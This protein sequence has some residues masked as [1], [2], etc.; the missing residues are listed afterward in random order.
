MKPGLMGKSKDGSRHLWQTRTF[1]FRIKEKTMRSLS[2]RILALSLCLGA[3]ACH[4]G[5]GGRSRFLLWGS[6]DNLL[7]GNGILSSKELA[8]DPFHSIELGSAFKVNVH[9]APTCRAVL[10]GDSNLLDHVKAEVSN[11]VLFLELPSGTSIQQKQDLSLELWMPKLNNATLSGAV[12]L[13][14]LDFQQDQLTLSSSGASEILLEGQLDHMDAE[15]SGASSFVVK[16]K[17]AELVVDASGA[18]EVHGR[19]CQADKVKAE[20]SGA[21]DMEITVLRELAAQCSGASDLNYW[22]TPQ[23]LQADATGSSDITGH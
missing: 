11:G 21:S 10:A 6:E 14:L 13:N 3:L 22:G 2:P 5:E 4:S 7:E 17:V 15:L 20:L 8:I 19:E 12:E 9:S 1:T 18:S 23:V 16:G